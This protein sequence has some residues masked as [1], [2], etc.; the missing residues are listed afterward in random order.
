MVNH[1][2][3]VALAT[4]FGFQPDFTVGERVFHRIREDVL[5]HHLNDLWVVVAHPILRYG[6][7]DLQL[8]LLDCEGLAVHH[9]LG[10]FAQ[11]ERLGLAL[12]VAHHAF[13]PTDDIDG[14]D[15]QILG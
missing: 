14:L 1:L 13:H 12:V 2:D 11:V 15:P 6:I 7:D 9:R 3:Q 5:Q 10:Q 8:L 4:V